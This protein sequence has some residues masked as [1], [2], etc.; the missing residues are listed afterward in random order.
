M[1]KYQPSNKYPT[2]T[3]SSGLIIPCWN[4]TVCVSVTVPSTL[5]ETVR[6]VV[7]E[8]PPPMLPAFWLVPSEYEIIRFP[9]TISQ[10]VIPLPSFPLLPFNVSSDT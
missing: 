3:G 10:D 2:F 7:V 9:S 5:N 6:V 4:N 1:P 8:E